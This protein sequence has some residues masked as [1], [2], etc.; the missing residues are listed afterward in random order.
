VVVEAMPLV[1]PP[2][3]SGVLA[4][5]RFTAAVL[6]AVAARVEE[7]RCSPTSSDT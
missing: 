3:G 6:D 7:L 2:E 4:A 1:P 5:R